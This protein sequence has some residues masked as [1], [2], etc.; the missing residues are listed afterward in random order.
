MSTTPTYV[1]GAELADL[2]VT[3]QDSDGDVIDFSSGW[4]FSVKVGQPGSAAEF[5][6]TSNITGAATA[7]NVTVAWSTSGELNNLTDGTFVVQITATRGSDSKTRTMQTP[8]RIAP[9]IT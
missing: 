7:P 2:A 1:K 8:I 3:W 4:T 9:A 5:T 6:K